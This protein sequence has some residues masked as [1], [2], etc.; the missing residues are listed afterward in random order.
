MQTHAPDEVLAGKAGRSG[1]FKRRSC[2][3]F[4]GGVPSQADLSAWHI[5]H[6]EALRRCAGRGKAS[7]R[8]PNFCAP[9]QLAERKHGRAHELVRLAATV[10]GGKHARRQT[11]SGKSSALRTAAGPLV[12]VSPNR[13]KRRETTPSPDPILRPVTDRAHWSG[14]AA[15]ENAPHQ[16]GSTDKAENPESAFSQRRGRAKRGF[17]QNGL[18][19]AFQPTLTMISGAPMM[20]GRVVPNRRDPMFI[21]V[22]SDIV[23]KARWRHSQSQRPLPAGRG[24]KGESPESPC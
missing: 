11:A 15:P 16:T 24:L 21:R 7:G 22:V 1:R 8:V 18:V 13:Q 9:R 23:Y 3:V 10:R 4:R 14:Y 12:P 5:D 19:S 20:A 17:V 2:T 6:R